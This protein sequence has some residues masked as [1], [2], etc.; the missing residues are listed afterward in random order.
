MFLATLDIPGRKRATGVIL[1][2]LEQLVAIMVAHSITISSRNALGRHQKLR[3]DRNLFVANMRLLHL[4]RFMKD[5]SGEATLEKAH[6][7]SLESICCIFRTTDRRC[8]WHERSV[9]KRGQTIVWFFRRA[10]QR[11]RLLRVKEKDHACTRNT[12]YTGHSQNTGC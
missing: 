4:P 12:P 1:T 9:T 6:P 8:G 2:D 10:R 11:V 7:N 5:T 3:L